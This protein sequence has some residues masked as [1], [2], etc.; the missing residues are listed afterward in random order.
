MDWSV[1]VLALLVSLVVNVILGSLWYGPLFGKPWMAL[2]GIKK[3]DITASKKKGMWKSYLGES[4]ATLVT[5]YVLALALKYL[6][7]TTLSSAIMIAALA[8]GGFVA[9][10]NVST[11]VW[12]GRSPKLYLIDNGYR[13]VSMIVMAIILYYM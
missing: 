8:W 7:P 4:L 3:K 12:S 1:N 9:A 11:L 5:V 2:M 10:V 6:N 13:L